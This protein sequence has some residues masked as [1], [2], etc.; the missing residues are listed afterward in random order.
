MGQHNLNSGGVARSF[1]EAVTHGIPIPK[2]S[3][4][5]VRNKLDSP[6]ISNEVVNDSMEISLKVILGRGLENNWVVKWAGVLDKPM[7]DPIMV[8]DQQPVN[9]I[10]NEPN[11]GPKQPN[12]QPLGSEPISQPV[13]IKKPTA[14]KP[15]G[16]NK[17]APKPNLIWR[18][19]SPHPQKLLQH[20]DIASS[21]QNP[22][23][24]SVHSCDLDSHLSD[25]SD[26]SS[27]IPTAQPRPIA[28][29]FQGVGAVAKTW[30]SSNDWFIDLRDGRRLRIPLDL[31]NPIT[32]HEETTTQKLIQWVSSQ[33]DVKVHRGVR[34]AIPHGDRRTW[35][36]GLGS[37]GL[38]RS[39]QLPK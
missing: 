18:P 16:L 34:K 28:E 3:H 29:V 22:D 38:S 36:M 6:E 4:V 14:N 37:L 9:N 24:V 32:D 27:L 31:F 1:K 25:N 30:G 7:G 33:R 5:S 17:L 23:H 39:V 13:A 8:E 21:S 12:T 10:C 35:R 19:R 26:N 15:I 20:D 2:I 11:L